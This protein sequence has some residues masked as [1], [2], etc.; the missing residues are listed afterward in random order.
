M[1]NFNVLST[2]QL[3]PAIVEKAKEQGIAIVEQEAIHVTPIVTREKADEIFSYLEKHIDYAV[4]TSSNAVAAVISL[5]HSYI[6]P[7]KLHWK[8][9]CLSGKT[10]D[11]IE[12]GAGCLGQVEKTGSNAVE[13]AKEIIAKGLKEVIFFCGNKRRDELPVI[14]ETNGIQVHE[15]MVYETTETPVQM[16]EN[17]EAILFFSPSA[18]QSFFAANQ[19]NENIV[20]FA[21][22]QTTAHSLAKF[23]HNKLFVSK[24]PTQEALLDE[25]AHYFKNR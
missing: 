19:L 21:I 12:G 8:I 14:L 2:K 22:G 6:K 9:F 5:C 20:C 15:V 16:D 4:F 25:V 10:K 7:Y 1:A 11:A 13:L 3:Q 18:V 17:V 23:T 24:E